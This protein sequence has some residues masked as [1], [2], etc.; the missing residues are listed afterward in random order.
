VVQT[1][2]DAASG[3]VTR[4]RHLRERRAV[5]SDEALPDPTRGMPLLARRVP[6]GDQPAVDH[7]HPG[8]DSR[9][10]SWRVGLARRRQRRGQRLTHRAAMHTVTLGK[11]SDRE[12]LSPSVSPDLLEQLHP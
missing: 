8:S 9:S 4:H 1:E 3:D 6:I 11:L 7:G 12:L 5:L 2:F 10:S